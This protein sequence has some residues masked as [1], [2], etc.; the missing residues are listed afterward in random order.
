MNDIIEINRFIKLSQCEIIKN[1]TWNYTLHDNFN[2]IDVINYDSLELQVI[3]DDLDNHLNKDLSATLS[4]RTT[5]MIIKFFK[6]EFKVDISV[7]DKQFIIKK[8][9]VTYHLLFDWLESYNINYLK[10]MILSKIQWE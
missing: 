1:D 3:L 5:N 6:E 7:D 10:L 2:D 8:D 4:E 9:D